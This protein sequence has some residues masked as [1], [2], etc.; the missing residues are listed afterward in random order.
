MGDSIAGFR[1]CEFTYVEI[2]LLKYTRFVLTRII[3]ELVV[4]PIRQSQGRAKR[5]KHQAYAQNSLDKRLQVTAVRRIQPIF[6]ATPP[7]EKSRGLSEHTGITRVTAKERAQRKANERYFR[8]DAF[9]TDDVP[10]FIYFSGAEGSGIEAVFAGILVAFLSATL[11][12][13]SWV[14][15]GEGFRFGFLS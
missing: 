5:T 7:G 13:C 6:D 9:K 10:K 4:Y 1:A 15:L 2:Q 8:V 3:S 14:G 12:F 11:S